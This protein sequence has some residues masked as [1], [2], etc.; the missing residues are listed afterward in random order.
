VLVDPRQSSAHIY[1]DSP[2]VLPDEIPSEAGVRPGAPLPNAPASLAAPGESLRP[3][4]LHDVLPPRGFALLM[5]ADAL[6]P[7]RAAGPLGTA[8]LTGLPVEPVLI[9]S[10]SSLAAVPGAAGLRRVFDRDGAL[11][12]RFA[13][14]DFPLYLIRPDEHVAARFQ[15]EATA[16]AIR[17]ALKVALGQWS[18]GVPASIAAQPPPPAIDG[19]IGALGRE[20][21]ERVFEAISRGVDSAGEADQRFLARLTL[22]LADEVGD[23]E[24]VLTLVAAASEE[25]AS[26]AG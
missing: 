5:F 16:T 11:A 6:A 20:G 2:L 23:P 26:G 1:D 24:R 25:P 17:D 7:E 8:A 18:G 9:G 22:L 12:G 21:L 14:R 13:A 10:E 4:H 19:R 3:T 15:A